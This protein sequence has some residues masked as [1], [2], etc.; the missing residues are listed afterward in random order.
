MLEAV[1]TVVSSAGG[2]LATTVTVVNGKPLALNVYSN[3]NMTIGAAHTFQ[4]VLQTT[5]GQ[6]AVFSDYCVTSSDAVGQ[7]SWL[8]S[9]WQ[10]SY[11]ISSLCSCALVKVSTDLCMTA[12]LA[13]RYTAA[14]STAAGNSSSS[15]NSSNGSSS[16]SSTS[17]DGGNRGTSE[18]DL[19]NVNGPIV[20]LG[21]RIQTLSRIKDYELRSCTQIEG[22]LE[23]VD[24]AEDVTEFDLYQAFQKLESVTGGVLIQGNR[25]IV[26]LE[27]LANLNATQ[28]LVLSNNPSLVDAR[29]PL[30]SSAVPVYADQNPILCSTGLP[31]GT[32]PCNEVEISVE[33]R[34]EGISVVSNI[35]FI[36]V[37]SLLS[38]ASAA[39]AGKDSTLM[40]ATSF[41]DNSTVM[42]VFANSTLSAPTSYGQRRRRT[43]SQQ[44][45]QHNHAWG[46]ILQ[47][48]FSAVAPSLYSKK[49]TQALIAIFNDGTL[50]NALQS[51]FSGLENASAAIVSYT[52][53]P[54]VTDFV[55]GIVTSASGI[56]GGILVRWQVNQSELQQQSKYL[57]QFRPALTNASLT[58]IEN[59]ARG[60]F[61][62]LGL[63]VTNS[64]AY[65]ADQPPQQQQQQQLLLELFSSTLSSSSEYF[66]FVVQAMYDATVSW[67]SVLAIGRTSLLLPSCESLFGSVEELSSSTD[68]EEPIIT[69]TIT[70]K[71]TGC[72]DENSVYEV[73]VTDFA[74]NRI[75]SASAYANVG[76]DNS[77]VQ[78]LRPASVVSLSSQP[79]SVAAAA[80][81]WEHPLGAL[82]GDMTVTGYLVSV[83]LV[84]R[85][86]RALSGTL[87]RMATLAQLLTEG[88]AVKLKPANMTS[89]I[90]PANVSSLTFQGCY[91]Y[92]L[93]NSSSGDGN[94]NNNNNNNGSSNNNTD[95]NNNN[96]NN[97]KQQQ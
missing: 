1:G 48:S 84:D 46:D 49:L 89:W 95:N 15:S 42:L 31:L 81:E 82:A 96:N 73:R 80:V 62:R 65:Q 76:I 93:T 12:S 61:A 72:V 91:D 55:S 2:T 32:L 75:V 90:L 50:V 33:G 44:Q 20:C 57:V 64:S 83:T 85:A 67:T 14:L 86:S 10:V 25:Q 68:S 47:V 60:I 22:S 36:E 30:I 45:Q 39:L 97:N 58:R 78:A 74:E 56:Q 63:V 4:S 13:A 37:E 70:Q 18:N 71:Q 38:C 24:L 34:I 19:S 27:F 87:L 59:M 41:L 92:Q 21:G 43:A 69:P 66:D 28:S 7:S 23:I 8:L 77:A 94:N 9:V 53:T 79:D 88:R 5:L 29:L 17:S 40:N 6:P 51:R 52:R 3:E 26:T 16:N 54:L 35:G 11:R